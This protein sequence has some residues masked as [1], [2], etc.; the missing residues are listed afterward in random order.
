MSAGKTHAEAA[1]GVESGRP[2]DSPETPT[3]Q[4]RAA[5][6]RDEAVDL[7]TN[8]RADPA[9][10]GAL[11]ELENDSTESLP[12][13]VAA[14]LLGLSKSQIVDVLDDDLLEVIAVDGRAR[15]PL[16]A[17]HTSNAAEEQR[18]LDGMDEIARISN[19]SGITE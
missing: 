14:W 10:R 19:E 12:L 3:S 9:L 15:I 6:T 18:A 16:V 5:M 2:Q 4:R 17:I 11:A 7:L 1:V 13:G 8:R